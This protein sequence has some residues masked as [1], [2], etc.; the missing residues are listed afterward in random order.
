MNTNSPWEDESGVKV[1]RFFD[2]DLRPDWPKPV[3]RADL[4]IP[5]PEVAVLD[6]DD[7]QFQEFA[8]DPFAFSKTY[9]VFP[10]HEIKWLSPCS[11]PPAGKGLPEAAPNTRWTVIY[12]HTCESTATCMACPQTTTMPKRHR[13]KK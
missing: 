1:L 2:S 13:S 8:A 12:E 4:L 6:L 3:K 9:K 7:G 5:C 10:D 11:F